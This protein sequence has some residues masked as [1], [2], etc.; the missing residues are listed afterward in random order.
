MSPRLAPKHILAVLSKVLRK[1]ENEL[2]FNS[3]FNYRRII[4]KINFLEK[5][6]RSSIAYAVH[7]CAR[8]CKDTK[9]SHS[10]VV[11]DILRYLATKKDK[12]LALKP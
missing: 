11:E 6:T 8:F 10:Q 5:G 2:K 7:Q 3:Y 9:V 1:H 4:R 12:R